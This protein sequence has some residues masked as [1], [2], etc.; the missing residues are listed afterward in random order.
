MLKYYLN[1][2]IIPIPVTGK[3]ADQQRH[4]SCQALSLQI[5]RVPVGSRI[6]TEESYPTS[7]ATPFVREPIMKFHIS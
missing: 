7:L 4:V 6:N 2:Q 3:S 1:T 5:W